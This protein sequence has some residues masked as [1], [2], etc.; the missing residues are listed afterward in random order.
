MLRHPVPGTRT[1]W[2]LARPSEPDSQSPRVAYAARRGADPLTVAFA[3]RRF[4]VPWQGC[5]PVEDAHVE[6]A[7][8]SAASVPVVAR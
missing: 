1:G 7:L 3:R 4:V 5:E 2:E 6:A 8:P